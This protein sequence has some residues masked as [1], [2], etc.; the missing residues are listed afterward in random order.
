MFYGF[1]TSKLGR[2]SPKKL[3]APS[4]VVGVCDSVIRDCLSDRS[5]QSEKMDQNWVE[6]EL[7]I[8]PIP[9]N[10]VD[11]VDTSMTKSNSKN[12]YYITVNM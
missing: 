4:A 10:L 1:D 11:S 2:M 3:L 12:I 8:L 5:D 7:K 9:G 6:M